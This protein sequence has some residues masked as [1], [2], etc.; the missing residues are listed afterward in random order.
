M[1]ELKKSILK[2]LCLTLLAAW[3]LVPPASAA[4]RAGIPYVVP[5]TVFVQMFEWPWNDIARECEI[6]LG[7]AGFSA[8]QVSPPSEHVVWDGSPWWERYQPVSYNLF[9]RSG[10]EAELM[11]MISRCKRAGVDVY[12]DAVVNHMAGID[13]GRG[14]AGTV[15]SHYQYP[16]LYAYDDFHHCG[17]HRESLDTFDNILNWTDRYEIQ[18]CELVNLADLATEKPRVR[19]TLAEYLQRFLDIGAA[20]F[21]IDAAK[22]VP[23]EDLAAVTSMLTRPAY[24]L[25]ELILNPGEPIGADEY[26]RVG[27]ISVFNFA[28][29]VGRA[30]RSHELWKLQAVGWPPA[31]PDSQDAVVFIENHDL[32]RSAWTRNQLVSFQTTP[33]LA[34]LAHVFMLA[35][36]YGYPQVMSSYKFQDY[37]DGPPVASNRQTLPILA[38]N[39][40]CYS[41]W[42]CEHRSPEVAPM[43]QFRNLTNSNFRYSDWWASGDVLAFGRGD[44]GFVVINTSSTWLRQKFQTSLAPGVY[45]N[46]LDANYQILA[47]NCPLES[48]RVRVELD[49]TIYVQIPPRQAM[50]FHY[51]ARIAPLDRR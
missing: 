10:T 45:C 24:I 11:S 18:N 23:P 43:V 12:I 21:R 30:F 33:E 44:A 15:F 35:W 29:D 14:H 46:I 9:S 17:R 32:Q 28:Y 49:R 26:I 40:Q 7:P 20:G 38:P 16:G 31:Y 51:G 27:D 36:P 4:V 5:R 50:A 13:D 1:N 41:P 3:P 19:R 25:Q 37:N 39:A 22:H 6:F 48:G 2:F 47:M 34:A 42:L 8:V